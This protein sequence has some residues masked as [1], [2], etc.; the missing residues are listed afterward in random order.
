MKKLKLMCVL[1]HPDDES[2]ATGGLLARCAALGVQTY[3]LT[4]TRGEWGWFGEAETYPGPLSLGA[5]REVEL[6]Q[7]ARELGICEV[8]FLDYED[9]KLDQADAEVAI[10]KIAYHLRRIKPD[11]VVTFDPFGCYGHPDHIAISQFTTAAIVKAADGT[12]FDKQK[13]A[14]HQVLKLYYVTS[15]VAKLSVYQKI[16]GD[17][18]MNIDGVERRA[19]GW[20]EWAITT[21]I[22]ISAYQ[23]T[24]LKAV[25]C[26]QTQLTAYER[27][28]SLSTEQKQA[29]W[30]TET[31]YRAF[32]MVNGGREMETDLFEGIYE[33][34]TM[35][36][37]EMIDTM[38]SYLKIVR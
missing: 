20:E 12:Y 9:G 6:F 36:N 23:D 22:D 11:V 34:E 14:P 1:A 15:T 8:D 17:L 26:H 37:L 25:L 2:L 30:T 38:I 21:A 19:T 18:V 27:L 3:L 33:K 24:I 16:F 32:S 7:A 35:S 10:S 28:K 13:L 4:A 31:Y 29:L 5:I